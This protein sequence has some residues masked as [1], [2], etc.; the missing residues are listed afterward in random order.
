MELQQHSYV[1]LCERKKEQ[2]DEEFLSKKVSEM[3]WLQELQIK[4]VVSVF[5]TA[6]TF[7]IFDHSTCI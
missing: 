3:W 2:Y 7:F 6:I 4:Y 1:Q 5:V